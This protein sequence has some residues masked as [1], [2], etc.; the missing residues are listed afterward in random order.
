M[1]PAVRVGAVEQVVLVGTVEEVALA[2]LEGVRLAEAVI[3]AEVERVAEEVM[4]DEEATVQAL[5]CL[6]PK[7]PEFALAAPREPFR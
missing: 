6:P 7:I 2:L 5:I 4:D 3:L 1:V